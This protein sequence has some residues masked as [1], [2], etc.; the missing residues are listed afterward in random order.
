MAQDADMISPTKPEVVGA[1]TE[2]AA[3][4]TNVMGA[5]SA[6]KQSMAPA[7]AHDVEASGPADPGSAAHLE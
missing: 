5:D 3:E 4:V 2:L 7:Q 1:D 6:V